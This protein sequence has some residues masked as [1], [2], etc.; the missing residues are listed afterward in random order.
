MAEAGR[1]GSA[2]AEPVI[3]LRPDSHSALGARFTC[4]ASRVTGA[5]SRSE[6]ETA[7]AHAS[8]GPR[9]VD[10]AEAGCRGGACDSRSALGAR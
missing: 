1:R 8:G 5:G 4:R 6:A 7:A 10:M 3:S 9:S 2:C